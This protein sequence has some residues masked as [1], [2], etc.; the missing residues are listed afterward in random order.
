MLSPIHHRRFSVWTMI[1]AKSTHSVHVRVFSSLL[2]TET[3]TTDKVPNESSPFFLDR[4]MTRTMTR[5]SFSIVNDTTLLF[6]LLL[7]TT[8]SF[9]LTMTDINARFEAAVE[10]M[11]KPENRF[12]VTIICTTDD[13]QADF[14]MTKLSPGLASGG[15]SSFPMVIAVSEDWASSGAGNGLGTLYAWTKAVALAKTKF[16][17]D[18]EALVL[19]KTISAGLFHTAGKGTR[20]APLPASE[21]NNKPG[22]VRISLCFCCEMDD[23]SILYCRT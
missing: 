19:D 4:R 16:N 17:Q 23:D 20:M 18:L 9:S 13:H 8:S 7:N 15:D 1:L 5:F 3:R 22:V 6:L 2:P 10:A 11:T 14:W 21:N 12:D